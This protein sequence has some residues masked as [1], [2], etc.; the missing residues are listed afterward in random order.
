MLADLPSKDP[1]VQEGARQRLHQQA[2]A[3][4]LQVADLA[5]RSRC[6]TMLQASG[7]HL[8]CTL[9]GAPGSFDRCQAGLSM[10]VPCIMSC[11]CPDVQRTICTEQSALDM[12]QPQPQPQPQPGTSHSRQQLVQL[13]RGTD[14]VRLHGHGCD[15][16]HPLW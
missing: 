14:P 11:A 9:V 1:K 3:M 16:C 8:A 12:A 5:E 2:A 7:H 15:P 13:R 6:V 4:H 10:V